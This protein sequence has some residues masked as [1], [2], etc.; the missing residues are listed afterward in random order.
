[1]AAFLYLRIIW[2]ARH[3]FLAKGFVWSGCWSEECNHCPFLAL[4]VKICAV[5]FLNMLVEDCSLGITL[6]VL[7]SFCRLTSVTMPVWSVIWKLVAT[8]CDE[9]QGC[10]ELLW[11][12]A[13]KLTSVASIPK[14]L[15]W[16]PFR[17]IFF[18][19]FLRT[20]WLQVILF[21]SGYLIADEF[22]AELAAGAAYMA[23]HDV[24]G[25]PVLVT[26]VAK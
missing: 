11:T 24:E 10:W 1:M 17:N 13:K 23:G 22:P 26:P 25:R 16:W 15:C 12:G 3:F 21:F 14:Q 4:L 9:Q 19:I 5:L 20:Q 7:V 18:W 8:T 6:F 2:R